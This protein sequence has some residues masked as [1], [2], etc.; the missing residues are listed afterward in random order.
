MSRM[1]KHHR[2]HYWQIRLFCV[3][4]VFFVKDYVI[5]VVSVTAEWL[6]YMSSDME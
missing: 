5:T 6:D 2:G 4:G 3:A 1:T